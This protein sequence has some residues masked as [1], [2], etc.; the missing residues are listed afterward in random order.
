MRYLSA[1][2]SVAGANFLYILRCS[3]KKFP[4]RNVGGIRLFMKLFAEISFEKAGKTC[5]VTSLVLGHFVNG[6]V[7]GV[8]AE[9]LSALCDCKLAFARAGFG[10]YAK[11]EVL[12][13]GIGY[14]FAKKFCKLGS[15]LCLFV[16]IALV[17]FGNLGIALPFCNPC[18]CKVHTYFGALAVEVGA[19]A[20][21]NFFIFNNA[22]AY[23]ML[24]GKLG[25]IGLLYG[26]KSL[27]LAYGA[28]FYVVGYYFTANSTSFHNF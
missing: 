6:I 9:L 13:G 18:H 1:A 17:C 5:A 28:N 24:A 3:Q 19:K 8:V 23:V 14:N 10:S 7:N 15:V 21:H 20:F 4:R 2:G 22:V 26:N 16:S 12:L 27:S 25:C 11:F